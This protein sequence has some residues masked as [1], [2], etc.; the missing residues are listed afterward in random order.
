[1]SPAGS[2]HSQRQI[3]GTRRAGVWARQYSFRFVDVS[4]Y[5]SRRSSYISALNQDVVCAKRCAVSFE[6]CITM[7]VRYAGW[8]ALT[9]SHN[10]PL[11]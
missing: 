7:V 4:Q 1:M 5:T 6:S 10:G 11:T 8:P 9:S 2:K 3:D